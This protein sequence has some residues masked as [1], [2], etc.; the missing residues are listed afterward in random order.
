MAQNVTY[1]I[2]KMQASI[3]LLYSYWS[4]LIR[5]IKI[6]KMNPEIN[7]QIALYIFFP[8]S[9]QI[10]HQKQE[11]HNKS[12]ERY[13]KFTSLPSL[14]GELGRSANTS[15]IKGA[16][17]T[18][19]LASPSSLVERGRNSQ[20]KY[21]FPWHKIVEYL[22]QKWP[23]TSCIL[24]SS[25]VHMRKLLS[26]QEEWTLMKWFRIQLKN[27]TPAPGPSRTNSPCYAVTFQERERKDNM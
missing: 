5:G 6:R 7:A 16:W 3:N 22:S 4:I 14:Q 24:S 8:Y 19:I 10:F 9:L 15:E 17:R 21:F 23:Q 20:L 2:S 13:M 18:H 11:T 25:A 27:L 12:G 26:Y 1:F